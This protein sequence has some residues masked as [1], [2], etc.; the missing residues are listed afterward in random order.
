[1][2]E[3]LREIA[4]S[5]LGAVELVPAV[6]V[7]AEASLSDMNW[8]LLEQLDR[9]APFGYGNRE[10][11]FLSRNVLIRSARIVGSDH[12][13]MI[14]SDG[15]VV[16]DAIAFRQKDVYSRLGPLPRQADIVYNLSAK[17]WQGEPRLQ[18]EIKD[19]DLADE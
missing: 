14:I 18:L 13:S 4:A 19:L 15:I 1:L 10:P 5:E 16:W 3:R 7:D 11:V 9:L 2:R 17:A 8:R 6:H 12:V